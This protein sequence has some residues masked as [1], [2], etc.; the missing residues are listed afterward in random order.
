MKLIK[1]IKDNDILYFSSQVNVAKFLNTA[2]SYI[3]YAIQRNK[4]FNGFAI[5]YSNDNVMTNEV[6][7]NI[8][9]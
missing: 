2:Q 6:D 8:N 4:L 3:R 7:K 1:V 9:D 5:S